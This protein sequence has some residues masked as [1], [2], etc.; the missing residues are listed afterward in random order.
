MLGTFNIKYIEIR[1][2][3]LE[4]QFNGT[5]AVALTGIE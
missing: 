1:D 4:E 3:D 5:T 2:E